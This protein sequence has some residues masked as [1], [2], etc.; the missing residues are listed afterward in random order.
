MFGTQYYFCSM[1]CTENWSVWWGSNSQCDFCG[2][3]FMPLTV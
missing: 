1:F 3:V 2:D